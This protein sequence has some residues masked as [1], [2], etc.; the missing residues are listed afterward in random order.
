MV[1]SWADPR[2]SAQGRNTAA[3]GWPATAGV[4]SAG[5][6]AP[7]RVAEEREARPCPQMPAAAGTLRATRM[8]PPGRAPA[9]AGETVPDGETGPAGETGPDGEA[10]PADDEEAGRPANARRTYRAPRARPRKS[11]SLIRRACGSNS[12][13]RSGSLVALSSQNRAAR[14]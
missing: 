5:W 4:R 2:W 13:R 7:G 3:A 11:S 10:G 14:L 12:S 9:A 1:A 8:S 6:P